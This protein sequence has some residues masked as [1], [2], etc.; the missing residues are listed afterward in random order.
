ML[1]QFVIVIGLEGKGTQNAT[2][3][4]FALRN[5]LKSFPFMLTALTI[6][7][8]SA[9][10]IQISAPLVGKLKTHRYE[11]LFGLLAVAIG[12]Q[13]VAEVLS[14][15]ELPA[16]VTDPHNIANGF[17]WSWRQIQAD[18]LWSMSST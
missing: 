3:A 14:R 9:G 11:A 18:G 6:S 15:K 1:V 7:Q 16:Y 12:S 13:Y 10:K 4:S 8:G 5:E 2:C 17:G